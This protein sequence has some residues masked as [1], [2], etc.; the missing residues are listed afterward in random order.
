MA[1]WTP[2]V[3]K[4][5]KAWLPELKNVPAQYIAEPRHMPRDVAEKCGCVIGVDYPVPIKMPPRQDYG[6]GGGKGGGYGGG[7][8]GGRGDGGRGGGRNKGDNRSKGRNN[9]DVDVYG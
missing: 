4:Y 3:G 1:R 9:R 2:L 8:G 5:I 6:G 7:R